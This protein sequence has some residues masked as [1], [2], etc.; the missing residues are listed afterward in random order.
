MPHTVRKDPPKKPSPPKKVEEKDKKGK[1]EEKKE[2]KPN[3][4]KEKAEKTPE[5]AYKTYWAENNILPI[6][7]IAMMIDYL[8]YSMSTEE[9]RK[10]VTTHWFQAIV[11]HL[12]FAVSMTAMKPNPKTK[13]RVAGVLAILCVI[14]FMNNVLGYDTANSIITSVK[15]PSSIVS[16]SETRRAVTTMRSV[17]SGV[18]NANHKLAVDYFYSEKSVQVAGLLMK[19]AEL[20]SN[21]IH[22]NPD[23]TIFRGKNPDDLGFMQIN[24]A[25]WGARAKEL[26]L[27]LENFHDNLKMA[28]IIYDEKGC[29]AWTTCEKARLAINNE[30][31][32]VI[33]APINGWS[34]PVTVRLNCVGTTDRPVK[35]R[36]DI[37]DDFDLYPEPSVT[38]SVSANSFRF[39]TVEGDTPAKFE[40]R[41]R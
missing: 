30:N 2:E 11:L 40:Y 9:I 14:A 38:K 36:P 41:C 20:E 32:E 24:Q 5:S 27:D 15:D 6:I 7:V 12:F 33:E 37:G 25:S 39:H 21:F 28:L 13:G 17:T 26:G 22:Q 8:L 4:E 1:V 19:I 3:P 29:E 16:S 35:V 31:V 23:G 34:K 10:Q 18:R